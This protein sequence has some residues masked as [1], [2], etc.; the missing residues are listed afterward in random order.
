M[1]PGLRDALCSSVSVV[2]KREERDSHYLDFR[3][4]DLP[5]VLV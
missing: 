4:E 5:A 3:I 2:I 1:D